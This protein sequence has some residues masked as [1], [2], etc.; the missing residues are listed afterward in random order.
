MVEQ[1]NII[2]DRAKKEVG[3][4]AKAQVKRVFELLLGREPDADELAAC[5]NLDLEIVSRSVINTNEFT[6]LP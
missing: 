3:G 1:S 5:E 6:F 2:A 4:D